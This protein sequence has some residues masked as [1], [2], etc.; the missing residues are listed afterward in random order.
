MYR[1]IFCGLAVIALV[2]FNGIA[3][4]IEEVDEYVPSPVIYGEIKKKEVYSLSNYAE[5]IESAGASVDV[6][7]LEDIR[8]QGSPVI[9][10]L[11]NQAAGLTVQNANGSLGSPSTIRLRG[12]DR[13]RLTIDGV[14]GDRPSLMT[15]GFEPQFL[16]SDDLERVEIIRGMQGNVGGTN[17][18]GGLISL[19]TRRGSGPLSVEV[20]SGMG[21]IGSFK[22]RFAVMYGDEKKDYYL[23]V[24]WHK[25]DG[26]MKTSN[27]G[28]IH[29]DDYNNLNLVSN[30]GVRVFENKAE[31]RNIFRVSKARKNIG[32]GFDNSSYS[33]Y[34][35]PNSY[36]RNIDVMEVLSFDH[37]P[38]DYY[39][40]NTKFGIYHNNS[41]NY[42][43]PDK[44][45][46]DA[47]YK[48]LSEISSTRL[49]FMTQHN[50]KYKDWNTVSVGYNL[51]SEFIDTNTYDISWGAKSKG[52][53]DGNTVQN[54]IF[55]NDL[56]NIKD[57]LFIRG[58][59]R[60]VNN[61]AFGTYVLPNG[62]AA[63]VLPT[64]KING[65][66]TKFRTSWGQSVNTPT[67]YQRFARAN[68]GWSSLLPNPN[69]KAETSNGW[70]AGIEQSFFEKKLSFDLGYFQNTYRD[71]ISYYSD[72]VTWNSTYKNL[73]RAK[74]NGYEARATWEPNTK[75]KTVLN[76]TYTNSQD[77]DTGYDLPACPRN[78]INGTIYWTPTERVT[79][80]V[81]VE[82][83]SNRVV[84][85]STGAKTPAYVDVK[86]GTTV[87]LFS[88]K[89]TH[90]YFKT[91]VYNLLNQDISMYRSSNVYY[92]APGIHFMSGIFLKYNLPER[93]KL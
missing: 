88:V 7:N 8:N 29:N 31:V 78:R 93:D 33:M 90:V 15:P 26:G 75:F 60:L 83:A 23:G 12:T 82:A 41:D 77:L 59:A 6:I 17:T 64:F 50:V 74:V 47:S 71:Y 36:S 61:S 81:G 67:L 65:A 48:S 76:Y 68:Y 11:L 53:F 80:F 16:L 73:N 79:S 25:T 91:V 34:Q 19:Q 72:P 27:L 87:R 24:T 55:V 10:D 85:S 40:Y 30:I 5:P 69:L 66:T 4:A 2:S 37:S 14:R 86:L 89:S 62:S 70:D 57:K 18:S 45:N 49:N 13:V 51:E 92:Y 56:I 28:T 3:C 21:N 9:S 84:S 54:D 22:E 1:K 35:S 38:K 46:S 63:L 39:N 52:G 43:L 20:E 58:G 42:L 32:I 44:I